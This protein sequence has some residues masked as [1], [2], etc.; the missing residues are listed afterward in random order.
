MTAIATLSVSDL[1]TT[2]NHEPRIHDITL[3]K[4]LGF[5]RHRAI[6]QIVERNLAELET[7]G[8]VAPHGVAQLRKNGATHEVVEYYL[9]EPQALLI[10]MFS[11]TER[12][13]MVR[14][15]VID[16][17]MAYRR[18]ILE[19]KTVEVKSHTRRLPPPKPEVERGP[20]TGLPYGRYLITVD[21]EGRIVPIETETV[22]R[23]THIMD[24]DKLYYLQKAIAQCFP[25]QIGRA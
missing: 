7:Y 6:R 3:G 1:N 21:L 4:A 13:A 12:A 25:R 23:G 2:V 22:A 24:T 17:F 14:K 18:G 5:A 8:S 15:E 10:C 16:V 9:N 11:K 20:A 19:P